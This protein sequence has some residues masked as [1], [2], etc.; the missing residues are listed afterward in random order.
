MG[1]SLILDAAS[2]GDRQ[3]CL[4][5]TFMRKSLIALSLVLAGACAS[6]NGTNA[7]NNNQTAANA[8]SPAPEVQ[9][10]QVGGVPPAA[11]H[12]T[13]GVSVQYAVEVAN[14]SSEGITLKRISVQSV[15]DGAYSVRHSQPFDKLI[16]ASERHVVEFFAPAYASGN[17]VVGANGP[18]TVRVIAEFVGPRGGFQQVVTQVVNSGSS[19]Q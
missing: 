1:E 2:K 5:F 14:P 3:K 4:S 7:T 18:V 11:R 6:G 17:S 13:G 10:M 15:S 9:I 16:P 12:V 8:T 19:G